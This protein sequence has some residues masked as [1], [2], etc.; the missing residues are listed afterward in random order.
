MKTV[1][2]KSILRAE[3]AAI[4]QLEA[5]GVATVHEAQGR[6]G[7]L[8]PAIR[9]VWRGARVA[10]SA[11]TALTAPGDNWMIHVAIETVRP[12]DVLVVACSSENVDG[13]F[14]ELIATSLARRGAK[15]VVLDIGCRDSREIAEMRLPV[16]SRAIF[17]QG[18]VKATLGAVNVPVICA[19]MRVVPGDVIVADDDG[20]VVVPR[21]RAAEVAAAG[22][23]REAKEAETRRRLEAGELG[24]DIYGMRKTLADK[25]LTYVDGPIDWDKGAPEGW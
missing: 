22:R 18:T 14:G 12:G 1:A 24:L 3:K 2:V 9:P 17:A 7:L 20:V 5:M 6:T 11:I 8:Q 13:G 21:S 23:A 10:G 15:G 25:G 19:G 4:D 16:W